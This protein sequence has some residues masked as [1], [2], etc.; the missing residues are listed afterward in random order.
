MLHLLI[1]NGPQHRDF[2]L[3]RTIQICKPYF[4]SIRILQN[5]GYSGNQL[6]RQHTIYQTQ[7]FIDFISCQNILKDGIPEGDWIFALDSDERPQQGLLDSL[8]NCRKSFFE[9]REEEYNTVAFSFR[10]HSISN[11]GEV[12][13]VSGEMYE[14]MPARLFRVEPGLTSTVGNSTHFGYLQKETKLHRSQNFINHYKHYFSILL[15]SLSF[16]LSFPDSI[17]IQPDMWEYE[18]ISEIR[19][20][21][22]KNGQFS[23]A[24]ECPFEIRLTPA[25]IYQQYNIKWF[26]KAIYPTVLKLKESKN[27]GCQDIIMAVQFLINNDQS[28]FMLNHHN[29]C[30]RP[31][32]EYKIQY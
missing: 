17:G 2:I 29:I 11:E 7:E 13:A 8:K 15:S 27:G 30:G 6:I 9:N 28:L 22:E 24:Y 21:F 10:H 4:T 12:I 1:T 20:D 3:E 18:V 25:T 14:F 5:G 26:W 19:N 23:S 32:C 31:C 16:G